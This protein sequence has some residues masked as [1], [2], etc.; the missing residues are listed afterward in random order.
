MKRIILLFVILCLIVSGC[1]KKEDVIKIAVA[2]PLTG[3]QAATGQDIAN[4]VKLAVEE[5]N[6]KG[7]L[8]K[9]MEVVT[10]DDKADPKEAVNVAHRL[11]VDSNVLV[12]IGHMNSGCTLPASRIYNEAGLAMVTPSATNPTIT[13]QGFN[14]VFR[15]CPTD[16][17]QGSAAGK[18]VIKNLKKRKVAILHDKTPYGQ[19]LAEE[20][21]KAVK[22]NGGNVLTFEGIT[23]GEMDYSAV[24]TKIKQKNPEVLY[25]GGMYNEGSLLVK[26]MVNLNIKAVFM[27]GDGLY[28][29]EFIRLAG[30]SSEGVIVSFVAPPY[31]KLEST[32]EF[33]EKFTVKYGEIKTYAPYAY[34]AA[35]V[36]INALRKTNYNRKD[37]IHAIAT[38]KDF[39]GITGDI[40]FDEKGDIL[41]KRI[42]FYKVTNGKFE[43][44]KE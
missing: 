2:V 17:V 44:I 38:T 19:G 13:K 8:S 22:E 15:V 23:P 9:K 31:D 11:V 28:V 12:V 32:K 3:P 6:L 30:K 40:A 4:A 34:D 5:A 27:S 35:N 25:F 33:I 7:E 37:L 36:I 29:P 43:W 18:F 16:D 39:K 21:Q 41:S 10:Y 1:T 24:L 42:Y 14:N 20:F 26:Q